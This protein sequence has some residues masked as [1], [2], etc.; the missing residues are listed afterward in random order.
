MSN[1]LKEKA[2][3]LQS[4]LESKNYKIK[5]SHCLEAVSQLQTGHCYNVAKNQDEATDSTLRILQDNEHLTLDELIKTDYS[6]DVVVPIPL[7]L[8]LEGSD[9]YDDRGSIGI[10][11]EY[12]STAILNHEYALCDISYE[13]YPHFYGN[14][15]VAVRVQ[16]YIEE[17]ELLGDSKNLQN[18]ESNLVDFF[19]NLEDADITVSTTKQTS[20]C[21]VTYIDGETLGWWFEINEYLSKG[22]SLDQ[23]LSDNGFEF[24]ELDCS[25]FEFN[26]PHQTLEDDGVFVS[27]SDVL[28]AELEEGWMVFKNRPFKICVKS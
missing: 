6:V 14:G 7:D 11:N 15:D 16:G 26:W 10:V 12:V 20:V 27:L 17:P 23:Y 5:Y 19:E 1:V 25:F 22:G 21:R 18:T 8:F 9:E 28:N 2:H 24:R 3:Q 13:V 4:Y